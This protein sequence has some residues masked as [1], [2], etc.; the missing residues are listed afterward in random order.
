MKYIVAIAL[1]LS[2]IGTVAKAEDTEKKKPAMSEEQKKMRKDMLEKYDTDKDGKLS[3][4]ERAKMS[5]E[6]KEKMQAGMH[7]KGDHKKSEAK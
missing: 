6:D 4:E 2:L 7:K 5:A 3:P 1:G